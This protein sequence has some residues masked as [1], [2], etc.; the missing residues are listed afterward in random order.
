MVE[1]IDQAKKWLQKRDAEDRGWYSEVLGFTPGIHPSSML[2]YKLPPSA[3]GTW[4]RPGRIWTGSEWQE[5]K[6]LL[7]TE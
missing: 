1:G 5:L 4:R 6:N 3:G 2:I 7:Q